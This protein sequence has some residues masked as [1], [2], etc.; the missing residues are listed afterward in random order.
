MTRYATAAGSSTGE[1]IECFPRYACP[2]FLPDTLLRACVDD[3]RRMPHLPFILPRVRF[4]RTEDPK[5]L[6]YQQQQCFQHYRSELKSPSGLHHLTR[7]HLDGAVTGLSYHRSKRVAPRGTPMR[8]DHLVRRTDAGLTTSHEPTCQG[9][10][11][12]FPTPR[13]EDFHLFTRARTYRVTSG[14]VSVSPIFFKHCG[15]CE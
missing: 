11:V 3:A 14:S 8:P 9:G 13:R 1:T 6:A 10:V 15:T 7:Q 5:R 4:Q 12:R 2:D